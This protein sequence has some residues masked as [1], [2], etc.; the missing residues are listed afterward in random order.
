MDEGEK[1]KKR[2]IYIAG[3]MG[4]LPEKNH[5]AFHRAEEYLKDRFEVVNPATLDHS[6]D[7]EWSD[8][9]KTDIPALITCDCIYLLS[10]WTDSKGARLERIIASEL[11]LELFYESRG[12]L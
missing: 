9:M 4:G 7:V 11:G 3:K 8:F 1:M 10:S 5:P 12:D 6:K 2:R